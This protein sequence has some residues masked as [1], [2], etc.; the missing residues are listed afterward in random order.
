MDLGTMDL[1]RLDCVTDYLDWI[2]SLSLD[3]TRSVQFTYLFTIYDIIYDVVF[4]DVISEHFPLLI[5]VV[6]SV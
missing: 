5:F 4:Y 1:C 6:I 2:M 3:R